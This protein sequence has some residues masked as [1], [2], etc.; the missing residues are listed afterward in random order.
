MPD[1]LTDALPTEWEGRAIDP[2]FRP[3]V[4]MLNQLRRAKT[5]DDKARLLCG[6]IQRF[7]K[8][9]LPVEQ[10]EEAF[11]SLSRFCQGGTDEDTEKAQRAASDSGTGELLLDY[12]Y[13][14]DYIVGAFQQVY[15]IDLTA[16]KVHWW[17]FK[18][19]L[20]ALPSETPLAK[21]MDFRCADTSEMA[22]DQRKYYETMKE[23][24]A[25]PPELKGVKRNET[26]QEHENT[27]LDRFG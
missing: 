26:L 11:T 2:D 1:L 19:L 25:L 5:D 13:D 23:R 17:R 20:H 27:F 24:Y 9:P 12:H 22:A 8:E 4:W 7:F 6:A 16:D 14:A 18:A 10:Y 15:G 3:M 21:V